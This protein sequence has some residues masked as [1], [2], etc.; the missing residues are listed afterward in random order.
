MIKI[1]NKSDE[2]VIFSSDIPLSLLNAIRRNVNYIPILAVDSLEISE[3]DSALYDEIIAHRVGLIPLKN[4]ELKMPE[5]C[6][7][8]GKGCGKCSIKFKLKAEGPCTVYS[9]EMGKKGEIS[10]KMPI[11][12]LDKDQALEFVAIAKMGKGIEHAKFS[13]GLLYYKYADDSENTDVA[14]DDENFKKLVEN[15]RKNEDREIVVTI[16]SWGQI[17]A[18]EIFTG[19]IE[20][21]NK[22]IKT[23]TKSV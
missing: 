8:K 23:L 12:L 5:D 21:L 4:V 15:A 19:A 20:E 11:A 16:E 6:D 10:Y 3:N 22:N 17:K 14:E 2:K 18:K 9:N 1:I 7:C 13:P